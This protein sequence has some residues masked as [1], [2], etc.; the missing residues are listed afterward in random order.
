MPPSARAL[1]PLSQQEA[2]RKAASTLAS[3][4]A[5]RR[6]LPPERVLQLT[7]IVA[8]HLGLDPGAVTPE[9]LDRVAA[10]AP[11]L[12]P[13]PSLEERHG[14]RVVA[15]L[16]DPAATGDGDAV[17]AVSVC[18]DGDGEGGTDGEGAGGAHDGD[19]EEGG[20]GGEAQA[21]AGEGAGAGAGPG[22]AAAPSTTPS[23]VVM[24]LRKERS[25][26]AL[27]AAAKDRITAFVKRWREHFLT[28]MEPRHMPAGWSLEYR[29]FLSDPS[30]SRCLSE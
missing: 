2:A 23:S 13:A 6:N 12:A 24:L 30:A 20:E 22:V 16:V 5:K 3:A 14:V 9:H 11:A 1:E 28:S 21:G 26:H 25:V 10:L 8:D 7:A 17:A 4:G 18:G 27:D 15:C 29:V 19:G